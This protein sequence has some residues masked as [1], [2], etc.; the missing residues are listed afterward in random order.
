M[1]LKASELVPEPENR[2]QHRYYASQLGDIGDISVGRR[3]RAD[4]QR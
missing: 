4:M 2:T 3:R 1:S